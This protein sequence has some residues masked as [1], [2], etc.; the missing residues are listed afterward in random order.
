[1]DALTPPICDYGFCIEVLEHVHQPDVAAF[2]R[3]LRT[4]VKRALFL[5]TPESDKNDHG[6]LTRD[7]VRDVLKQAGFTDVV[8]I[9]EQW[10]TLYIAQ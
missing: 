7:Q 6:T 3:R 1:M 2:V 8:V 10:T 5:S 4:H 9:G